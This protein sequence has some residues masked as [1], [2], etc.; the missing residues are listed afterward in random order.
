MITFK[1]KTGSFMRKNQYREILKDI[2][3]QRVSNNPSYSLRAFARDLDLSVSYL[4]EVLTSKKI[5]KA[6]YIDQIILKLNL[7]ENSATIFKESCLFE[8]QGK[9][10]LKEISKEDFNDINDPLVFA[11]LSTFFLEDFVNDIDW[12]SE[13]LRISQEKCHQLINALVEKDILEIKDGQITRK[14]LNYIVKNFSNPEKLREFHQKCLFQ[15]DQSLTN[16]PSEKIHLNHLSF[17]INP[18]KMSTFREKTDKYLD[19]IEKLMETGPQKD[20][21]SLAVYLTPY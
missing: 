17:A 12:I 8:N 3:V 14:S 2:F 11:L 19:E 9:S 18:D 13:K 10:S 1:S 15:I 7:D 20:L 4:S 6:T 16:M 21:Y 5:L